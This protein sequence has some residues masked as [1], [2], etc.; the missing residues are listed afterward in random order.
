M[1]ARL[2]ARAEREMQRSDAWWREHRPEAPD[3]FLDELQAALRLLVTAPGTGA[4]YGGYRGR[5]VRRVPMQATRHQLY[6]V[7]DERGLH[8]LSIWGAPRRRP[9]SFSR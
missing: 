7:V 4:P 9:P 6:Y 3:L 5:I 8:V 1:K 2:S